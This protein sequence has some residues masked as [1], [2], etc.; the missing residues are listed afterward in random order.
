MLG[1]HL[2]GETYVYLCLT[3]GAD[4]YRKQGSSDQGEEMGV[5][6][7]TITFNIMVIIL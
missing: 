5:P 1:C 7:P 2:R 3:Y 6:L 4:P